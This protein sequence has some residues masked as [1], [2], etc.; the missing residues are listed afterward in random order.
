MSRTTCHGLVMMIAL[1]LQ[2]LARSLVSLTNQHYLTRLRL[3]RKGVAKN[4]I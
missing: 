2:S 3:H 4:G 1:T